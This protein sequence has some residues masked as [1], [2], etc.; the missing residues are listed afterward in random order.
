MSRQRC[1][2]SVKLVTHVHTNIEKTVLVSM[3]ITLRY[4]CTSDAGEHDDA[5]DDDVLDQAALHEVALVHDD[6]VEEAQRRRAAAVLV[7]LDAQQPAHHQL[8]RQHLHASSS[9]SSLLRHN[10]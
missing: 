6:G 9:I 2:T 7:R 10:S 4:C 3:Y 5:T 1:N 8:Q